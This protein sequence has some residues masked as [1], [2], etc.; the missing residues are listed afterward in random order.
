MRT[1]FRLLRL[2]LRPSRVVAL[3]AVW[4]LLTRFWWLLL[5]LVVVAW[6][7]IQSGK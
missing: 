2:G 3:A 5:A 1:F 7:I 6:F 4:G